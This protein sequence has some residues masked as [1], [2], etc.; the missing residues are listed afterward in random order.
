MLRAHDKGQICICRFMCKVC[1]GKSS[2]FS[3]IPLMLQKNRRITVSVF[4]SCLQLIAL[5]LKCFRLRPHCETLQYPTTLVQNKPLAH[6]LH[7][8]VHADR[9]GSN[10]F[11]LISSSSACLHFSFIF[12]RFADEEE[13]CNGSDGKKQEIGNGQGCLLRINN[14]SR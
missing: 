6:L 7:Y 10:I 13:M 11:H 4:P 9:Y 3:K 12:S 1:L 2:C 5:L 8:Q 14:R